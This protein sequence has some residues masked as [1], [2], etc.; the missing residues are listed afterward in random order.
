MNKRLEALEAK[1]TLE[2]LVLTESQPVA[3]ERATLENEMHGEFES[4]C[5]SDLGA[6]YFYV[7]TADPHF[8]P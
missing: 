1:S 5:P 4:E 8:S 2:G 6:G 7:G 3:L